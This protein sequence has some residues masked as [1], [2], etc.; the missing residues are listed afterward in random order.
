MNR[1]LGNL[2]RCLVGNKPSQ[3][4]MVLAQAEFAYNNSI[5]RSTGK[6][7]FEIVTGM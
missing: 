6:R 2:I 4:K 5:N 1:I 7:P 3:W